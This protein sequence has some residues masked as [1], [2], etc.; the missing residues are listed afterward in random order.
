M[1]GLVI[2]VPDKAIVSVFAPV[3]VREMFPE[4]LP[5]EEFDFTLTYKVVV[6]KVPEVGLKVTDDPKP[7]VEE[8]ETS[9]FVG[10]VT[11]M[12]AVNFIPDTLKLCVELELPEQVENE[13]I[14]AL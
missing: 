3:L 12:F 13:F 8:L 1:V 2:T 10:A 5:V 14:D 6:P 7:V 9:K 11:T 4:I